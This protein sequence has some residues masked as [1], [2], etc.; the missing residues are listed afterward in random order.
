M[1]EKLKMNKKDLKD[2]EKIRNYHFP[3]NALA[4]RIVKQLQTSDL[5]AY[6]IFKNR[7][8]GKTDFLLK[9]LKPLAEQNG[10][11]VFYFS[12]MINQVDDKNGNVSIEDKFLRDFLYFLKN[13]FFHN[14]D[15]KRNVKDFL[16]YFSKLRLGL[17]FDEKG[18]ETNFDLEFNHAINNLKCDSFMLRS[19][20]SQISFSKDDRFLLLLDEF[21]DLAK[22]KNY[23]NF[24]SDLRTAINMNQENIK[25]IFTGSSKNK[26]SSFFRDYNQ[27]FY[28][29]GSSL[30]LED[31]DEDFVKHIISV[32]T[33]NTKDIS[34]D[35]KEVYDAFLK[36]NKTPYYVAETLRRLEINNKQTFEVI[37][38]KLLIEDQ[39]IVG[40]YILYQNTYNNLNNVEKWIL[41]KIIENKNLFSVS[42]IEKTNLIDEEMKLK[43]SKIQYYL[44][45]LI[46]NEIINKEKNNYHFNDL[47][48]LEWLKENIL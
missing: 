23:L 8:T 21:Q 3:R 2:F 22:S 24:C 14:F 18:L 6:N 10:V 35:Y 25:V 48:F 47:A 16:K 44:K 42:E 30:E 45:K 27:P 32:Y 17:K 7:R 41:S 38:K 37:F 11:K 33:N 13:N 29:F 19:L 5:I 40:K 20:F 36:T 34:I 26:L 39:E 28:N 4:N 9:D 43:K 12:F 46:K 15:F 1:F 31:L